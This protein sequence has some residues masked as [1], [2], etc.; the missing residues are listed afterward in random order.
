MRACL[1]VLCNYKLEEVLVIMGSLNP[2]DHLHPN[3]RLIIY[4]PQRLQ[5]SPESSIVF[6]GT[7]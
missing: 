7:L 2:Q 1:R 4:L 3:P 5:S 6:H